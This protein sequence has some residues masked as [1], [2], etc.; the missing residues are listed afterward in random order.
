[1]YD[2]LT[3]NEDHFKVTTRAILAND[4]MY[5]YTAYNADEYGTA[6][7]VVCTIDYRSNTSNYYIVEGTSV[8]VDGNGEVCNVVQCYANGTLTYFK[9]AD[10]SNF[11]TVDM[12]QG[13]IIQVYVNAV[14][15]VEN[16]KVLWRYSKDA[17]P[18]FALNNTMS[19]NNIVGAEVVKFNRSAG[20]LVVRK[21]E[22]YYIMTVSPSTVTVYDS[23]EWSEIPSGDITIGDYVVF[24]S[25]KSTISSLT[26]IK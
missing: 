11:S 9:A 3:G 15:K 10:T 24:K 21:N 25:T 19:S 5:T 23:G 13:D 26:V 8:M 2:L 18:E 1:M 14:G 17:H 16:F 6:E 20:T 4:Q 12:K 7:F 22:D